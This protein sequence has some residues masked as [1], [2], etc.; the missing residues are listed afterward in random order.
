MLDRLSHPVSPHFSCLVKY[1]FL[2]FCF[3][4]SASGG[5]GQRESDLFVYFKMFVFERESMSGRGAE[6]GQRIQNRLCA[7]SEPDA[8]LELANREIMT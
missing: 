2:L 3:R 8:G 5:E 6:R 7:D 1:F 4:E